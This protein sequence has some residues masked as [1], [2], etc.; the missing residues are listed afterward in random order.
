MTSSIS[1]AVRELMAAGNKSAEKLKEQGVS[2]D[3]MALISALLGI[4]A[5]ITPDALEN[6]KL[7]G[8]LS[9]EQLATLWEKLK[10]KPT[11]GALQEILAMFMPQEANAENTFV[12]N[13]EGL[14]ITLG[15]NSGVLKE[16]FQKLKNGEGISK[17]EKQIA[18]DFLK[19]LDE[20]AGK[21]IAK[22]LT[23]GEVIKAKVVLEKDD[24][25]ALETENTKAFLDKQ[26]LISKLKERKTENNAQEIDLKE[27]K[28]ISVK[29]LEA[30][31]TSSAKTETTFNEKVDRFNLADQIR[32]GLIS[33]MGRK[34]FTIRL[35]P[36]GIGD[37]TVN[38]TKL[39]D[40]KLSLSILASNKELAAALEENMARLQTSLKPLGAEV[41]SAETQKAQME[42]IF[43][44]NDQ[45]S[46]M[47][48]QQRQKEEREN[49][50]T[51]DENQ[52]GEDFESLKEYFEALNA[53]EAVKI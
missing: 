12:S 34:R 23:K 45:E 44:V 48:Q 41:V 42:R 20:S 32:D 4:N 3:F 35:K 28:P 11:D 53:A 2:G 22:Q 13:E 50:K 8:S 33:N 36:E 46:Q 21:E 31:D 16:I 15:E 38:M 39:S 24:T 6:N 25:N 47:Q 18:T 17:E 52:D 27:I 29:E 40:G 43:P 1:S 49:Q 5:E 30:R 37:I 9:E 14:A 7:L 51:D 10:E 26:A 19:T